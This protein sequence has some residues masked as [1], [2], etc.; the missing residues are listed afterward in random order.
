MW[1]QYLLPHISTTGAPQNIIQTDLGSYSA[2]LQILFY[3]LFRQ[4]VMWP[5]SWWPIGWTLTA[6][7]ENAR[8]NEK[9]SMKRAGL[10]WKAANEKARS[11]EKQS[12]KRAGLQ[13]KVSNEKTRQQ[14]KATNDISW[15]AM[16]SA[17]WK[18]LASNEKQPMKSTGQQWKVV[19]ENGW[20]AMKSS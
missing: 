3:Y 8:S 16:K 12:M 7:N 2:G 1:F 13:W 19:N 11:K 10:Q 15:A 17:Q 18:Q 6:A 9:W 4:L 5:L 20:T 14:W